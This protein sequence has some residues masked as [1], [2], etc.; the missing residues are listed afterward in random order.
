[1]R[2][3]DEIKPGMRQWQEFCAQIQIYSACEQI[4]QAKE[5]FWTPLSPELTCL[6][7]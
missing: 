1:M 6:V 5:V 7:N 3:K 2:L 4:F